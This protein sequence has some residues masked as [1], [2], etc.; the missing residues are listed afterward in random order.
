MNSDQGIEDNT[1]SPIG[2]TRHVRDKMMESLA[3]M[4]EKTIMD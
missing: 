4:K 1:N 3:F 2:P